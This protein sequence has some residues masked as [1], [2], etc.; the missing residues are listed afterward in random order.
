MATVNDDTGATEE[1][2]K[3]GA[4]RIATAL[5]DAL[6]FL[7]VLI[8]SVFAVIVIALAAP[9]ALAI[10]ALAGALSPQRRPRRWN[11]AHAG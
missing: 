4:A 2:D 11:G 9:V 7:A 3:D 8:C 5:V 10:S 1:S 6:V